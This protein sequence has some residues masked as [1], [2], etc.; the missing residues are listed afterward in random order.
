MT[1]RAS[2]QAHNG[3]RTWSLKLARIAGVDVY[4]HA[5]FF[6][7]VAW[8]ALLD[9]NQS[10]RVQAVV[11]GVG[12]ILAAVG[13][14]VLHELGHALTRVDRGSGLV[15]ITFLP[16]GGLARLQRIPDEPSRNCG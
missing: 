13:C 3:A 2:V 4:V 12:F 7:V 8:I 11:E 14:I 16:I 5:T 1:E 15:H 6:M 10:Q 9:W